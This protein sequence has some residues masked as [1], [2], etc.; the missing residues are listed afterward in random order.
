MNFYRYTVIEK[1]ECELRQELKQDQ[2]MAAFFENVKIIE[3]LDARE[4]FYGGRTNATT[5]YHKVLKFLI[6]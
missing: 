4:A 5:L 3:P 6:F 2:R 1:W